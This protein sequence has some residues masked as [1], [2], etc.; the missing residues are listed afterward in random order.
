M[1]RALPF[2]RISALL[3][4]A[5]A[6]VALA[7]LLAHSSS[8]PA[9]AQSASSLR[10][11]EVGQ[12]HA[13][14]LDSGGR[15]T[16]WGDDAGGRVSDWGRWRYQNER[17]SQVSAGS[18]LTCG[19]KTNGSVMC[20]GYPELETGAHAESTNEDWDTWTA[21]TTQTGYTGWVNTPPETVKF[22]AG[23]LS[24]G[25]YH[26]CAIKTDGTMACWGKAGDD[27]LVIPTDSGAAITDWLM[28]EAGFA[29][30]CGIRGTDLSE[31]GS[32]T[33]WG[34]MSHNRSAGPSGAGPFI[35]VT[36]AL[37]N[38][39]AL[40]A[41]GSVEC[42]G[43]HSGYNTFI[44]PQDPDQRAVNTQVNTAPAGVTFTSIE[45][46]T[47][48]LYGCGLGTKAGEEGQRVYCWGW[49]FAY[50]PQ[51]DAQG[52][53]FE[54]LSVG[55]F[56][57]CAVDAGNYLTCWG[58]GDHGV[59]RP[60]VGAFTQTDGG[61]NFSCAVK[62]DGSVV[63]WGNDGN[64]VVRETPSTGTFTKVAADNT[65]ACA[66]KTDGT[67]Q[68]WG[69][70]FLQ[71]SQYLRYLHAAVPS[72][73]ASTTFTDID[74]GPDLT[75]GVKTDG[76]LVC[77][78]GN[79]TPDSHNRLTVPSG[80]FSRV[81]VGA[82][83]VCAIKSDD[84]S[85]EC[86][87]EAVFFDRDGDGTPDDIGG[88]G[89]HTSTTPPSGAHAYVDITAGEG[90]TCA[91]R[92]DGK[93]VCWGYHSD[94]RYAVPGWG[95]D[96]Q[97]FGNVNYADIA[98]GGNPN[99]AIRQS[100]GKLDCWNTE[101]SQ[102]LPSAEIRAMSGFKSLGAGSLHMCA[103]RS[104][105]GLV[106]WGAGAVIPY[107]TAY[108][109][110]VT[111]WNAELTDRDLGEDKSG[112]DNTHATEAN[113]CS[114]ALTDDDLVIEGV[115]YGITR[116]YH[117]PAEFNADYDG[118]KTRE[119]FFI[120]FDSPLPESFRTNRLCIAPYS[121]TFGGN[122]FNS[123]DGR[124]MHW[125]GVN[126]LRFSEGR[127]ASVRFS[128]GQDCHLTI[129]TTFPTATAT[130][131]ATPIATPP[132]M[133][134]DFTVEP[135]AS[136]NA[137]MLSWTAPASPSPVTG[138]IIDISD[139]PD[140]DS[141]TDDRTVGGGVTTWTHTG[142]SGGDVKF[143]RVRARN[144]AGAGEWTGW[145]SVGA[146]P[147]AP[148][149]L[150]ARANGPSEIVLTWRAASS[151]D[152]AIF[153]YEI[154]YSDT[155]ASEGYWWLA[156]TAVE[157]LRH[158][159]E[160]LTPGDTRYYR[161]RA[162][163]L[164]PNVPAGAWSNVASA[165]TSEAGPA[166][167]A[168]VE[169]QADGETRIR[170]TWTASS[171]ASSYHVEHSTDGAT[172]DSER[173][174]HTGT[175]SVGGQ[176]LPCYTDSGLLSGTTHWYRVAGVN[177]SGAAGEWSGPVSATTDG[178]PTEPPGQPQ[179]LRITSVSGRQVSLS[180]DPPQ[181]DGGSRVTGYEYMAESACVHDP[182]NICQVIKPTRTSGT[183]ATVTVPNVKGQYEF[184]VRA[185]NAA[186]AG[187]WTQSVNQHIDPQR[188]WRVTLS[189]SSLRVDE[190]GEATY[191]VRLTSD[192]GRPVMVALWWDGDPDVGNTLSYQQFKWLLPSNYQN[193]DIYLD[194]EFTGPW[195]VGVTI[196]VT[197]DEDADSENGTAEIHNTVHYVPCAD[198]GSPAGCVD[199]PEDTGI[200]A[201]LTATERDND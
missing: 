158:V 61:V 85:I 77:W 125:W 172:W 101:K 21:R 175:C 128:P 131:T 87:G 1:M 179:D 62:S 116:M 5:A 192:P 63:C 23:S 93:A 103:I 24:V 4:L 102:Y 108:W 198:L 30:A 123:G 160:R 148:G 176:T 16:C 53:V 165:T 134:D 166:P 113:H 149:S 88:K 145:Q 111:V 40:A 161:V 146:G 65:H 42:W 43:G 118:L 34:R 132:D 36:L 70:V 91:I 97:G 71:G 181:D 153:Q 82:T 169:A 151:R 163:T 22:R 10:Q 105:N 90:H 142:L 51:T 185:L 195:N 112:C 18:F 200:T 144:R 98:T 193:P 86:W 89:N 182:G 9:G 72:A 79:A 52:G 29:H 33:C 159:D 137:A 67:V 19:I 184:S 20:W 76:T 12:S 59:T 35:D 190:G 189:P 11:I 130:A 73:E 3:L 26:A 39:C 164:E 199:D 157:G 94:G 38:G 180:W 188:T 8:Q 120:T 80:S 27:R 171:N 197:A 133:P 187:W 168:N 68:C 96:A 92:D 31:G 45:M 104:D 46:S 196:T 44:H 136:G 2:T 56:V 17:F 49:A 25:N 167:P 74:A 99:C 135:S 64:W 28:V 48:E 50:P 107:P 69:G 126:H 174:R 100:D 41:D 13:C 191:R 58:I 147:G 55:S 37:Y 84:K 156:L 121:L 6:L 106:C 178:D 7:V 122:G 54:R 119:N 83:H 150:R 66:I 75:C 32:V 186:G 114:E 183:S 162:T 81:A 177:R 139:S 57:N 173:T 127:S 117:D 141:R 155:S 129:P 110:P 15:V 170:L 194:P 140:G 124:T 95:S 115:N 201:R 60:P 47:T 138:Y 152:V 78:G 143:Y 109:P 14:A 154:E